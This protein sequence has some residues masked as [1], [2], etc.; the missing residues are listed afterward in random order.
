MNLI[1]L[2][3]LGVEGGMKCYHVFSSTCCSK[4]LSATKTSLSL[5]GTLAPEEG[6]LE[7]LDLRRLY[8]KN[9][10]SITEVLCQVPVHYWELKRTDFHWKVTAGVISIN[11]IISYNDTSCD[12]II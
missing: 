10:S 5:S 7:Y 3:D 8:G 11:M 6:F 2:E 1:L 4:E 12:Y 9:S